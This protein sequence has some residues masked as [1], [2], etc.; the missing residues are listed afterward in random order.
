VF[1]RWEIFT[2][3]VGLQVIAEKMN[4]YSYIHVGKKS[5]STRCFLNTGL[6]PSVCTVEFI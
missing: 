3:C 2:R 4:I 6:I 5:I 1:G